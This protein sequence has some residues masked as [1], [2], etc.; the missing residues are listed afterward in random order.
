MRQ[1]GLLFRRSQTVGETGRTLVLVG[2]VITAVGLLLMAAGRIPYLG[3]LPGDF[4]W[5][6]D[7]WSVYVPLAT[8]VVL[9][10]VLTLLLNLFL[11]LFGGQ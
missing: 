6:G 2:A 11:R 3:E 10:L 8:C 9:S 4:R 7:G 5:T 1:S